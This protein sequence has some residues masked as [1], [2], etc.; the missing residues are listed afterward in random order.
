MRYISDI[1]LSYLYHIFN[2]GELP[3]SPCNVQNTILGILYASFIFKS[4]QQPYNG[5]NDTFILQM[6]N[7]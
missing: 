5:G 4:S 2:C 1:Y 7:L 6:T 3:N